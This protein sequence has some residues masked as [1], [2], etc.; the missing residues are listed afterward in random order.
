M[1]GKQFQFLIV[2]ALISSLGI[3][4]SMAW[5]SSGRTNAELVRNLRGKFFR[6]YVWLFWSWS[7]SKYWCG[8]I[9]RIR[10]WYVLFDVNESALEFCCDFHGCHLAQRIISSNR[11]EQAMLATDR[12]FYA[13]QNPYQDSPQP[14]GYSATIS[15]P[16]MVCHDNWKQ[17]I[18]V[19]RLNDISLTVVLLFFCF[20]MATLWNYWTSTCMTEPML[21]ML[22]LGLAIWPFVWHS[23][24]VLIISSV[25]S[26]LVDTPKIICSRNFR[27][28]GFREV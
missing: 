8:N 27:V 10:K 26:V 3:I 28:C 7:N 19:L 20:S 17:L 9:V 11:V 25:N 15:A 21:W 22:V 14:I 2:L 18:V 23:W 12:A 24:L 16:H 6:L 13:P 4:A 1:L 5:R